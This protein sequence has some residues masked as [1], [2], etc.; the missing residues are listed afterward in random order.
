MGIPVS[1]LWY[2]T[3]LRYQCIGSSTQEKLNYSNNQF[4]FLQNKGNISYE[5]CD[6]YT[7]RAASQMPSSTLNTFEKWKLLWRF[8]TL[9][10]SACCGFQCEVQHLWHISSLFL[11]YKPKTSQTI[12]ITVFFAFGKYRVK[13]PAKYKI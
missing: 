6:Y 3:S 11:K 2:S 13:Q 5:I 7:F 4:Y 12:C 10:I 9:L 1:C 8:A